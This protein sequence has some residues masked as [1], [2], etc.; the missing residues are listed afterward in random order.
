MMHVTPFLVRASQTKRSEESFGPTRKYAL[1][2]EE[3]VPSSLPGFAPRLD[4]ADP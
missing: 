3:K 1:S 2:T 4:F